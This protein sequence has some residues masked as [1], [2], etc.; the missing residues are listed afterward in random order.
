M[1]DSSP[2]I[3]YLAINLPSSVERRE[4]MMREGEKNGISIQ[5]VEAVSGK[6]L[7][8]EQKEMY[9]SR[10][11]ESM[12]IN[13]LSPNEQACVHSHRKA[14]QA[15]L[16]SQA[17]Y[18]V[19]LEDDSVLEQN[20]LQGINYLISSVTGWECCKLYTEPSKLYPVCP[21]IPGAPVQPVFPKKI[22]WG[23]IGYMYSRKAAA[24]ILS[25]Y[26]N[27]WLGADTH[28]AEIMLTHNI[29]VIGVTPNLVTTLFAHNEE[30]DIDEGGNRYAE[31]TRPKR[32]ALQ[33]LR[34]RI[35]VGS[36][37][38]KKWKMRVLLRSILSVKTS[39]TD[40]T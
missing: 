5:I 3:I 10:K 34:Y 32:S 36:R 28:L 35:S 8:P 2:N 33:Y 1:S 26:D 21:S 7:T 23:A 24:E 4:H 6:T 37:A 25:H 17:D 20:F 16:D 39:A 15:I 18:G 27:F 19:I 11:R 30:S 22:P 14:L 13:H 40:R 31:I 9:N 38:F 12:Y 29:P